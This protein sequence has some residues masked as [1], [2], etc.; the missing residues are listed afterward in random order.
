MTTSH[1]T[2]NAG[3]PSLHWIIALLLALAL[4]LLWFMGYGPGGSKCSQSVAAVTK[5][6]AAV[7]TPVAAAVAPAV[8]AAAPVV[9]AAAPAAALATDAKVF[10]AD[11]PIPAARVYF[12][13]DKTDLPS[14]SRKTLAEVV[15]YLK[16]NSAA[17]ASLSGYHDPQ[18]NKA[19]NEELALNRARAVR[20]ELETLGI[21]KDRVIMQKPVET[22]GSGNNKEARR[23]EVAAVVPQK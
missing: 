11:A 18:G 15:A 8:V 1:N 2:S 12:A 13:S 9:A 19:R 3:T 5:P 4:A 20:G 17:K 10:Y 23:V 16:A 14:D 7:T 21:G 22:T 6:V